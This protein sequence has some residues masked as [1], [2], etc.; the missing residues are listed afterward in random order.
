MRLRAKEIQR[1]LA[2]TL[3]A[4]V[5]GFAGTV[6]QRDE[7][8][9]GRAAY[10]KS[11]YAKA[12][13]ELQAAAAKEPQDGEIQLLLTK[14]Y[15]ELQE[16][17]AAVR[18]AERAVALDPQNSVYHEWLG[19][20]YGEKASHAS[21]FAALGLAR[22]TQREFQTAVELDDRNFSARQALIEFECSAPGIA[23]G[24]ED[25]AK[26]Q[27]EQLRTQDAAEWHY[28]LGN[29]RRQ[30]KD[31]AAADDE[32]RLALQSHPKSA[33]LIYDIGDYVVKREQGEE[34]LE[35]AAL[36]ERVAPADPRRKYYRAVGVILKK[37]R[38]EEAE[39]LLRE[40]LETAP[41]RTAYPR[42]AVA[43]TWLGRLYEAKGNK[44]AAARE[45]QVALQLEPK[46]KVARDSLQRVEKN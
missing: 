4:G 16:Q 27:I 22:R 26:I 7:L 18:S 21:L 38:L 28:A 9:A 33:E 40:Y 15:I 45:Y 35:V 41:K 3:L 37:E 6:K 13:Q 8:Q 11:D 2:V 5:A 19:K 36:G 10:E 30:K 42:Y 14:S 43:H 34:L 25:K 39:R 24:G 29:C 1:A 12:V 31:F 44:G 20:A 23:G 32:F 17:D 46:N